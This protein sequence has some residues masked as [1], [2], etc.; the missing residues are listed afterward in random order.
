MMLTVTCQTVNVSTL[1]LHKWK[2]NLHYWPL[3]HKKISSSYTD[4][5]PV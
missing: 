1:V 5:N 3:A 2:W 4:K